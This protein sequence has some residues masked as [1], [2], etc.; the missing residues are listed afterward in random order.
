MRIAVLHGPNLNALGTREPD[1]YGRT[2]LAEIDAAL[3]SEASSLGV[4]V[5]CEQHQGEGE[6]IGA[7]HRVAA[8]GAAGLLVNPGAYTHYSY[9][10]ADALRSL[11]IP[12][13]EV[14]LSNIHAREEYRRHSVTAASCVGVVAGFGADSYTVGLRALFTYLSRKRR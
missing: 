6:L 5:S 9:A 11:S 1:V 2:T 4:E 14:H 10:V 13:V 12:A 8:Q 7:I 3:A